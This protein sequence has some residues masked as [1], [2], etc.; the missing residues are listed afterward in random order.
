MVS[1][2][3]YFEEIVE[4]IKDITGYENMRPLYSKIRRFIFNAEQEIAA[5]GLIVRKKRKYTK[6][7]G[8]YDGTNITMPED[9]IGEYSYRDLSLGVINGNV[10][11]LHCDGPDE[12]ELY[13]LGFLLD[14]NGNPFTTRNH[15]LAVCYYARQRMYSASVFMKQ[16]NV[17]AYRLFTQEWEDECLAARGNDAFPSEKE[18]EEIGRTLNGGMFE[19]L[20]NCGI[21]SIYNGC[22]DTTA[23][24]GGVTPP[25]TGGDLLPCN[26]VE[27]F[28]ASLIDPYVYTPLPTTT[29]SVQGGSTVTGA[30]T[31]QEFQLTS[32]QTTLTG[33]LTISS[34]WLCNNSELELASASSPNYNWAPFHEYSGGSLNQ[35]MKVSVNGYIQKIGII[36]RILGNASAD[37][38]LD[39]YSTFD[40]GQPPQS[41]VLKA[42]VTVPFANIKNEL[43]TIFEF[44]D[45]PATGEVY[46][47]FTA[48]NPLN[49]DFFNNMGIKFVNDDPQ[50]DGK[51]SFYYFDGTYYGDL[52]DT[53]NNAWVGKLCYSNTMLG[54]IG[55]LSGEANGSTTL[56]P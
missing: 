13:Y 11:T 54:T 10:M 36:T 40:A 37:I 51:Y 5:G 9:F 48:I 38:K 32:G 35:I 30:L 23:E 44:F 28:N 18:W 42:S 49:W 43:E 27:I 46:L 21:R 6:G 25:D 24:D 12:I 14:N 15:L 1:G 50:A 53:N 7:D 17:N 3:V 26:L 55:S 45:V 20:T 47:V 8:W 29:P 2:I 16:G 33:T 41:G 34:L 22:N 56:N 19:A 4:N 39:I 52:S 31:Y